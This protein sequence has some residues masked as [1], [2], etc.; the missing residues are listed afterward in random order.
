MV[1]SN[2]PDIFCKCF[3]EKLPTESAAQHLP[4][5]ARLKLRNNNITGN[6]LLYLPKFILDLPT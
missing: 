6:D 1:Y 4:R 5:L 2:I 3:T